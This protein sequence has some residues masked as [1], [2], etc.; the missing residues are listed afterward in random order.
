MNTGIVYKTNC[1]CESIPWGCD[2]GCDIYQVKNSVGYDS[3][4]YVFV[5]RST[6]MTEVRHGSTDTGME[7]WNEYGELARHNAWRK[8]HTYLT[9][10]VKNLVSQVSVVY[11]DNDVLGNLKKITHILA[12]EKHIQHMDKEA[13]IIGNGEPCSENLGKSKVSIEDVLAG[14]DLNLNDLI[15][16]YVFNKVDQDILLSKFGL[17]D[18]N[19]G[20]MT[21]R[22]TDVVIMNP[23]F[24]YDECYWNIRDDEDLNPEWY[25]LFSYNHRY[26]LDRCYDHLP[27]QITMGCFRVI[28]LPQTEWS[29]YVRPSITAPEE[30]AARELA[31]A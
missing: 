24:E 25:E 17:S 11:R 9:F 8:G 27:I 21:Q 3:K 16:R 10:Y 12:K 15:E 18:K 26:S 7:D 1:Y 5:K 23:E 20:G 14:S 28:N 13:Y 6:F 4:Y 19:N 29:Y 22:W 30:L 2:Y 31:C